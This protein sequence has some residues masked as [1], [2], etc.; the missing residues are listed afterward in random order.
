MSLPLDEPLDVKMLRQ[1]YPP[2]LSFLFATSPRAC[3]IGLAVSVVIALAFV[4]WTFGANFQGLY[5]GDFPGIWSQFQESG[6]GH[7]FLAQNPTIQYLKR[8]SPLGLQLLSALVSKLLDWFPVPFH[9]WYGVMMVGV[10][11]W[12]AIYTFQL[13]LL[14]FP[15]PLAG[16]IATALSLQSLWSPIHPFLL[17]SPTLGYAALLASLYYLQARS[18]PL[19]SVPSQKKSIR[20]SPDEIGARR[21]EIRWGFL[22]SVLAVGVSN[23]CY[24]LILSGIFVLGMGERLAIVPVGRKPQTIQ[25]FLEWSKRQKMR[26]GKTLKAKTKEKVEWKIEYKSQRILDFYIPSLGIIFVL[27]IVTFWANSSLGTALSREKMMQFPEF[28]ADGLW[29]YFQPSFW[30]FWLFGERS[31]LVPALTPPLLWSGFALVFWL[32]PWGLQQLPLLRQVRSSSKLLLELLIVSCSCFI[33]AHALFLRLGWPQDYVW[34]MNRLVLTIATS[35]FLTAIIESIVQ[36]LGYRQQRLWGVALSLIFAVVV[37]KVPL[38]HLSPP[39]SPLRSLSASRFT[40]YLVQHPPT[41]LLATIAEFQ[42]PSP[43]RSF[44][45]RSIVNTLKG[46]IIFH[47]SPSTL[48]PFYQTYYLNQRKRL[49][50]LVKIQYL[51]NQQQFLTFLAANRSEGYPIAFWLVESNFFTLENWSTY[52]FL[53]QMYP[54]LDREITQEITKQQ[55]PFLQEILEKNTD[56]KDSCLIQDSNWVLI[57]VNLCLN[58]Y[59]SR[60]LLK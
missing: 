38:I 41:E 25:E 18:Q 29:H 55:K 39:A 58:N 51:G 50:E 13:T 33:L 8:S 11:V 34:V 4:F 6:S 10:V 46:K 22:I 24:L 52:G 57:N 36:S 44:V 32:R 48:L 35:I 47:L 53:K 31:G 17:D 12:V 23:P 1:P 28:Y 56:Q 19:I 26:T 45:T 40:E 16:T 60:T 3:R 49:M 54:D 15:F 42:S 59:N 14:I 21:L 37:F 43:E 5:G 30:R 9:F 27:A 2:Y 7:S 20:F